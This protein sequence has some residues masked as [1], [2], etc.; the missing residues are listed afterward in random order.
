MFADAA[1]AP[2]VDDLLFSR[3]KSYDGARAVF[4]HAVVN[5]RKELC[6]TTV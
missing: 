4:R 2:F 6:V 5:L 3:P 1:R